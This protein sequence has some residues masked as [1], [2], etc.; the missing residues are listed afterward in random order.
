MHAL[1]SRFRQVLAQ[2]GNL[3]DETL[4]PMQNSDSDFCDRKSILG[5]PSTMRKVACP[6]LPSPLTT[7][8]R[9]LNG[10]LFTK[11]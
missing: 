9:A 2:T 6:P 3:K 8:D 1:L 10:S 7:S 5:M 4:W 11:L